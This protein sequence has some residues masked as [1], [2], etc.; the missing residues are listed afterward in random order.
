MKDEIYCDNCNKIIPYENYDYWEHDEDEEIEVI[1]C[2][3]CKCKLSV[4]W[5]ST[6]YFK[7]NLIEEVKEKEEEKQDE[8]I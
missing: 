3:H 2:P 6:H 1:E 4:S 8:N 7:C 5:Y